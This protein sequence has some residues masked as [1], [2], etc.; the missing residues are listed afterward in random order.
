MSWR[1]GEAAGARGRRERRG[2]I[3]ALQKGRM[4]VLRGRE[5]RRVASGRS[6][7]LLRKEGGA[8]GNAGVRATSLG[9]KRIRRVIRGTEL[10]ARIGSKVMRRVQRVIVGEV[11]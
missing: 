4:A 3:A 6:S 11:L 10:S 9:M 2:R 1:A 7:R 5:R 8:E